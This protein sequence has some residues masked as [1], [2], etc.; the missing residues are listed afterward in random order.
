MRVQLKQIG[1][2][3]AVQLSV[4]VVS[5]S[6][7]SSFAQAQRLPPPPNVPPIPTTPSAPLP[8]TSPDFPPRAPINVAP[9]ERI[10]TAP[11][12]SPVNPVAPVSGR[13][14]VFVDSD[15]SFVLQRVRVIQPD[16]FLQNAGG[17]RVIQA[18]I[19]NNEVNARQ[20]VSRLST[21]GIYAQITGGL[22]QPGN[23]QRGYYAV[24]P[25]NQF[26]VQEHRNRAIRLGISQSAVRI[27]NRPLGLHLAVG[28]FSDEGEA[29]RM[30][31]YLRDRGRMDARLFYAR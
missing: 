11:G 10:Y 20:Q 22:S 15:S 8:S 1:I 25:G 13:Y 12:V 24:V 23:P 14:R 18:G 17:R 29:E 31:R 6:V 5:L 30:V 27:R 19:F 4:A 28:P 7:E 21:Q 26:E 16:A 9:D 2:R 3:T